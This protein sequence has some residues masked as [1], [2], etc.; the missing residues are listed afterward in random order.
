MK[1]P[2][3][4][5]KVAIKALLPAIAL[6]ALYAEAQTNVVFLTIDDLS[7]ESMGIHG[8]TIPDITPHMDSIGYGG[9][10]FEHCHVQSGNC[11]PSRNLMVSGQYQQHN[12]IFSLG[13][14]GAGNHFTL[15]TIPDVFRAAGYHTGIMGK[16][17]HQQPFSPYSGWDVEYDGYGSTKDPINVY[18]KTVQAIADAQAL[19]KPLFYNLNIWDPHVGWYGWDLKNGPKV[20]TENHPSRIYGP[21]EM[22][23]PSWFPPMS[24]A[25]MNGTTKN[26]T[27]SHMMVEVAAYYNTVKRADD[28]VG[29][30]LQAFEEAGQLD[31]TIFVVVSD[32]GT[33]L[34][35]AK[36]TL[37]H[38]GS[39]SPLFIKWPGVT[40]SNTVNNT[41]MIASIDLLPTF[42][43]MVGQ[44]IPAGL[45]G[46]SFLPIIKGQTIPNWREFVYKQQN[47]RNKSRAI[48]TKDFLYVMNHWSDGTETFGS[49]SAGTLCWQL[50]KAAHELGT[51]TAATAWFQ[52]IKWRTVEELYD[53]VNDPDCMNNLINDPAHAADLV[54][55]R[56][57]M[58][59]EVIASGDDLVLAAVQNPGNAAIQAQTVLDIDNSKASRWNNPDYNRNIT[60]DP[61]DD[62]VVIDNT[63]FEPLGE[64]GI[65]EVESTGISHY[66]LPQE[67]NDP[68]YMYAGYTVVEFSGQTDVSRLVTS[69]AIDTSVFDKLKLDMRAMEVNVSGA[70]QNTTLTLQYN[71]GSGWKDFQTLTK[72]QIGADHN[73][74]CEVPG[75]GL[76]NA[77]LF[78]IKADFD[79]NTSGRIYIDAVRLT[80]WQEWTVQRTD[81]FESGLG[82]WTSGGGNASHDSGAKLNG[83]GSVK[84]QDNSGAAS[85][86]TLT[87]P[88]DA[89]DLDILQLNYLFH[90]E[91]FTS[92]DQLVVEY[93]TGSTW[94]GLETNAFDYGE[95]P[96]FTYAGTI[97]IKESEH[98]LSPNLSVRFRC[99]ASS[100]TNAIYIDD[101]QIKSRL[102]SGPV[103]LGNPPSALPDSYSSTSPQAIIVSAPGI[104][105]NDSGSTGSLSAELVSGVSSGILNF[106]TD[107]SFAYGATNGFTGIDSFVYRVFDGTLYSAPITVT[108]TTSAP[109]GG[110][111]LPPP[112]MH[113]TFDSDLSD[114]SGNSNNGSFE[115]SGASISS[116]SKFGDGALDTA[117]MGYV[118][119]PEISYL[120]TDDWSMSL[121][122]K[123]AAATGGGEDLIGFGSGTATYSII[124]DRL[125]VSPPVRNYYMRGSA[126]GNNA[127]WTTAQAPTSHDSNWHHIAISCTGTGNDLNFY[128]DGV[129]ISGWPSGDATAMKFDRIAQGKLA[130]IF[131][132]LIDE[133]WIMDYAL[134]SDQVLSLYNNNGAVPPAAATNLTSWAMQH[135]L[136]GNDALPGADTDAD[137]VVNIS[138]YAC[139]LIPGIKDAYTLP[140]GGTSGLPRGELKPGSKDRLQLEFLRRK[141][142]TDI[143]YGVQFS[144]NLMSNWVD[145][146]MPETIA[147]ISDEWE[148]VTVEDDVITSEA[149]NRFGRVIVIQNFP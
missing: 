3:P 36:T 4:A 44:P 128:E 107:G 69:R 143:S 100:A 39:V 113:L 123:K 117:G 102:H 43:E 79:G 74:V 62:W 135:G 101:I 53:M 145:A 45:D 95:L 85:T 7:R 12:L 10:R 55:M 14:E 49:V 22:P 94:E 121:W 6:M 24:E 133:V 149:T 51:N 115:G 98:T 15:P 129:E 90:S 130:S 63:M 2:P 120:D 109:A 26:G 19:G 138:E 48:Q 21:G 87:T 82:N 103:S 105:G 23:Y 57:L 41:D 40:S 61:H 110:G 104:M 30:M 11:T 126:S 125:T 58:E 141:N 119:F 127:T 96:N 29:K 56:N 139:N 147:P 65:W 47:D 77:M 108:L 34:P 54:A 31:N 25:E 70:A 116:T 17:S 18:E 8:C 140:A 114:S 20:E 97:D 106:Y 73:I 111:S 9:L 46:R 60:Y 81:N 99:E 93:Y 144:D 64:W 92:N 37:Y 42:C 112:R 38:H 83:S 89:S 148:R 52:Q 75:G 28:S 134:D 13:K 72:S 80:G 86:L 35:G 50:F 27:N 33:Q 1:T 16:N 122:Y 88:I 78:G 66:T 5:R 118:T 32:H 131:N 124:Y 84:L 146:T 91:N 67:K 132:G 71:D 59:Q 68:L 76:P 136:G 137:T 142:V